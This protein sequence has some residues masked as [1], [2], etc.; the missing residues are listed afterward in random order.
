MRGAEHAS[1][2]VGVVPAENELHV[3]RHEAV[4]PD[5]DIGVSRLLGEYVAIDV[6]AAVFE[7]DW[8]AA[9]APRVGKVRAAQN[10]DARQSGHALS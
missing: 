5:F 8:L 4:N 1:Q 3:I 7:E 9:I 2:G 6:I 10:S